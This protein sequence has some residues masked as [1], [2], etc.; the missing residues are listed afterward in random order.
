MAHSSYKQLRFGFQPK[1]QADFEGG[2]ITSDGGLALIREFD[3]QK[4]LTGD[5]IGCMRD[6]RD[7]RYTRH[8]IG[9]LVRQRLYQIVAGYEDANDADRLRGDPTFQL[10][11]GDGSDCSLGSQPTICRLENS[12]EWPA[13]YRLSDQPLNWFCRHAYAS[14]KEP[15]ELLLDV[16]GTDDPTHGNQQFALFHGAYD[17]HMYHPLCWF[18]AHTGLILKTRLRPGRDHSASFLVEDLRHMLPRLR[19]RFSQSRILVRADAGMATPE[20]EQALEEEG[21]GYVLGIGTNAVFK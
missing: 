2:T 1:L 14:D 12:V 7:S 21:I 20:V 10:V 16:D 8:D 5:V 9:T 17:Q 13:V 11:A 6:A 4:A 18:E 15:E 19:R 3:A